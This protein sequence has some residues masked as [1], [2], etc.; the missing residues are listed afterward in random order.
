MNRR[1]VAIVRN[2]VS[3][4][5]LAD[6]RDV[7]DQS[8]FVGR[9]LRESGWSVVEIELGTDLDEAA[10]TLKGIRPDVVFNL[11][12]DILDVG[13][14]ACL[15]PAVYRRLGLPFTGSDGPVLLMT[16]DKF[17]VKHRLE[18]AGLSTPPGIDMG[19]V[20]RGR[21]PGPGRYIVKSRTEHASLGLDDSAV[22][23]VST[24]GELLEAMNGF[25]ARMGGSCL[26]ERFVDGREFS[27]AILEHPAGV[28]RALGVAEIVFRADM[29][30]K[31]V[32][33]DAKWVEGS[34]ADAATVR[35]FSFCETE[36]E[37]AEELQRLALDCWDEMGLA[38]Y[39]R[40]DFRVDAKGRAHVIDINA[41]P[42][43]AENAGF[44]AAARRAGWS[45]RDV[46]D[47]I[48]QGA[49]ERN[50]SGIK[51]E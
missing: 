21:F 25:R 33:Y 23:D 42:C 24:A 44:M 49:M 18:A 6:A 31:I 43:I 35:S 34:D 4:S 14:L 41:N 36:P 48:V 2:H 28:G 17:A 9:M 5:A 32:G 46:M 13:E 1:T 12:E 8:A 51:A 50:G 37:L 39:A 19:G 22:V 20:K 45:D 29:P 3:A 11:V 7:L 10:A 16:N 27:V 47:A 38:G 15:A 40:I 30:V 26:A